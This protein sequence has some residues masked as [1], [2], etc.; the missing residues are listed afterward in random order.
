MNDYVEYDDRGYI[1]AA[2]RAGTGVT[3]LSLSGEALKAIL[4]AS[5]GGWCNSTIAARPWQGRAMRPGT[6][7]AGMPVEPFACTSSSRMEGARIWLP[8]A[9]MIVAQ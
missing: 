1:H 4:P 7:A 3:I 5:R 8:A 2:D 9:P 6:I